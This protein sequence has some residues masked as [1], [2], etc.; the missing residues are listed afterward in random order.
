MREAAPT[1]PAGSS[2]VSCRSTSYAHE[3]LY[4]FLVFSA[5]GYLM[6]LFDW[7]RPP[8]LVAVVLGFQ[9]ETCMWL[10]IARYAFAYGARWRVALALGALAEG[11][12]YLVFD[13]LLHVPWPQPLLISGWS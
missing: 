6:K 13:V 9:M 12:L 2:T 1:F 5:V 7:P 10:S 11:Y 8:V 4:A 3:D